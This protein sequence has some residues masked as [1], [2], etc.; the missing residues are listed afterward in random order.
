MIKTDELFLKLLRYVSITPDEGGAF[1]FIKEYLS[2]FEVIEVNVEET[3]N[4]FLYKRFGE[5]A[6]LCFA[7]HLDVLPPGQDW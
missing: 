2:D 3:K 1:A 5:G 7:V 6:H 4:L